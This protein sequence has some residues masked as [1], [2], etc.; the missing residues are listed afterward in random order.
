MHCKVIEQ[1]LALCKT[2]ENTKAYLLRLSFKIFKLKGLS[3]GEYKNQV[4]F[5]GTSRAEIIN[6]YFSHQKHE[7]FLVISLK[8]HAKVCQLQF[9]QVHR[10]L[11]FLNDW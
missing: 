9:F 4:T 10:L 11:L 5:S 8:Q 1:C 6:K 7:R 2:K 3:H